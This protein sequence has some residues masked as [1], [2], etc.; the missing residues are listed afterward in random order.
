MAVLKKSLKIILENLQ[1]YNR[2]KVTKLM[3]F[4]NILLNNL[5]YQS[6]GCRARLKAMDSGSIPAGVRRFK[7]GPPH[8]VIRCIL[9]FL[10]EKICL[11]FDFFIYTQ[12]KMFEHIPIINSNRLNILIAPMDK[13]MLLHLTLICIGGRSRVV[14][15]L[16]EF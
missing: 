9:G 15:N 1:N 13:A 3:E 10:Q 16:K 4:F 8:F 6:G 12:I 2:C 7:S 14:L 11:I 5:G